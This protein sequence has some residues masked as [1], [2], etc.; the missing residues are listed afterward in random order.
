MK[1]RIPLAWLQLSRA[2]NRMVVAIAGIA[3]ADIL[4]F[5]QM[6]FK[7][8]LY[9]SN[10]L[11]HRELRA[12]LFLIS[13]QARNLTGMSTF[14]RRR[15]YQAMSFAPV[16]SA[17]A[18][19]IRLAEWKAPIT[20]FNRLILVLGFNPTKPV[21]NL[22][23]V[24]QNLDKIKLPNVLLFDRGARNEY[25][26]TVAE[27]ERGRTVFTEFRGRQIK[28]NGLFKI[29]A[30]FAAD[31][32]LIASDQTFFR[33]FSRLQTANEVN[34]GLIALKPSSDPKQIA[35]IL[36]V[37]L[38]QDV[39]VL[40][41]AEFIEFEKKYW[42]NNTPIGFIFNLGTAI[43][44]FVGLVIFYQILYNDISE[45][46]PE[47]ATLKAIGYGHA[48]LLAVVFQQALILAVL[49]YIPG[50]AISL[51]LYNLTI[52]ATN[53]PLFMTLEKATFV[54]ALTVLMCSIAGAIAMKKIG[55]SD[56]VDLLF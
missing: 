6:G 9:N 15:L 4:M 17:D 21:C 12:D 2:K 1:S 48:Y 31:G 32:I 40:T 3:F 56:P 7:A 46:L 13:P 16:E 53:L 33:L 34:I 24:N 29:G 44:F 55:D 8:A 42:S 23:E 39:K 47:Y 18:L 50:F 54:L 19:Y 51:G 43:G 37:S 35:A 11:L 52:N 49:G 22:P 10:T 5:M 30:S 28:L 38:P 20:R 45:R 14:P 36:K 26:A 27:L 25:S 41:R